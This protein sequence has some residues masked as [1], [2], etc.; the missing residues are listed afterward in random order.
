MILVART[1]ADECCKVRLQGESDVWEKKRNKQ[2]NGSD[3]R[4]PMST[5]D[6]IMGRTAEKN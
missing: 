3:R 5:I 2:G 6:Y 4:S 1:Q